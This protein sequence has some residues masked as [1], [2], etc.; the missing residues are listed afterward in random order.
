MEKGVEARKKLPRKF[1]SL[2]ESFG[3]N[4]TRDVA[5]FNNLKKCLKYVP[6]IE[7]YICHRFGF[8]VG[9]EIQFPFFDKLKFFTVETFLH[10]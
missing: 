6:F 2:A 10:L 3:L 9:E 5:N 1:P 7:K 8:H 4:H